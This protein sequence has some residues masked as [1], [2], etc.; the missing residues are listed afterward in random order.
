[1][2]IP[3]PPYL[4]DTTED[5]TGE[6][7]AN[8]VSLWLNY[9]LESYNYLKQTEAAVVEAQEEANQAKLKSGAL[10]Q[11]VKFLTEERSELQR[12]FDTELDKTRAEFRAIVGYQEEQ[13]LKKDKLYIEAVLEKDRAVAL[14]VPAVNTPASLSVPEL[15][16]ENPAGNAARTSPP[17][18]AAPSESSRVSER[19]P[20]PEKFNGDRKDLRRFVSQIHEKLT[21]NR[22]RFPTPQSR[23]SYVTS[24]LSGPPYAQILPYI[25]KGVC[26]LP[27]YEDILDILDRAFGDPNRVNNARDELFRLRQTNKDFGSFF[28][29]FQRLALEGEMPEDAL[30]TILEQAISREL[31]GMLMH[32]DPPNR[33]YLQFATFLQDLENRRRQYGT[34][35]TPVIKSY[36]QAS[37]DSGPKAI[38]Q[39]TPTSQKRDETTSTSRPDPMD[40]SSQR[41][42]T[43][44][45]RKERG[46]CFRCGSKS[47]RVAQCPEPD[48]RQFMQARSSQLYRTDSPSLPRPD[49]PPASITESLNGV[50]LN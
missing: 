30:P 4:P 19:L 37:K 7:F 43:P 6:T 14:A 39:P 3:R 24:R 10:E 20:D 9:I 12:G 33:S 25:H 2:P 50:S 38:A 49:S 27:D 32:H 17:D 47:H 15:R 8:N 28:A 45:G 13:L 1:M 46:E 5:L 18:T 26:Q 36:A 31:R 11:Q 22:D 34:P 48:T 35:P 21:V 29:E 23:S 40:L 42:F 44:S 16:T 41:A